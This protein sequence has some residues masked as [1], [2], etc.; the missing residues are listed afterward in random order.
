VGSRGSVVPFFRQLAPTGRLPITDFRMTRFWITLGQAVQLVLQ[1][2]E[3]MHG[4]ELYV[5]KIPSVRIV[6]L[7]R[8]IA[9]EAELDE[10]GIRPGEKLHEEMISL[11]DARRTRELKDHYVIYPVVADWQESIPVS[12]KPVPEG[13]VYESGSND[14]WLGA[15]ELREFLAAADGA[16]VPTT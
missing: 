11:D 12:G 10:V 4:G 6:D 16:T 13:F 1:A 3:H 7:A 14:W 15:E 2:F 9:P 8:A 5:P